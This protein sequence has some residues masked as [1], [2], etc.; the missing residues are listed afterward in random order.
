VSQRPEQSLLLRL[1]LTL[2][3]V[4]GLGETFRGTTT[5]HR[6]VPITPVKAMITVVP[7]LSGRKMHR[8]SSFIHTRTSSRQSVA[9]QITTRSLALT[10]PPHQ[11][12]QVPHSL[13]TFGL[14]GY[15][16]NWLHR[17][18]ILS[19]FGNPFQAGSMH[20]VG[21]LAGILSH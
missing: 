5:H 8:Q 17:A 19:W 15:Q 11:V 7:A 12:G 16:A 4:V 1:R 20:A 21:A 18:P 10:I 13:H 9:F 6:D 14:K 3:R 2:P